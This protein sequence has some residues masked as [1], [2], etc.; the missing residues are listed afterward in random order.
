MCFCSPFFFNIFKQITELNDLNEA[1]TFL[2]NTCTDYI[3]WYEDNR[4]HHDI[5]SVVRTTLLKPFTQWFQS[6]VSTFR[7]WNQLTNNVIDKQCAIMFDFGLKNDEILS[8][9]I[10]DDCEKLIDG[11]V[12]ILSPLSNST[13]GNIEYQFDSHFLVQHNQIKEE[14]IKEGILPQF[15]RCATEIKF[16]PLKEQQPVL[17]ILLAMTF[18][19]QAATLLKQNSQFVSHLKTFLTLSLEQGVRRAA[20]GL[21]WKLEKED[22]AAANSVTNSTMQS[23]MSYKYDIM[24]SYSHSDKDLC[25]RLHDHLNKDQFRVCLNRDDMHGATMVAMADAIENS[26]F[27][28]TCMSDAYKQSAYCQSEAHYAYERRCHLIPIAMKPN[29]R[30]DGWLGFTVSEKIYIDFPKL[31]F[32]QTYLKLKNEIDQ[33]RKNFQHLTRN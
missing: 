13:T 4:R 14:L 23:A 11:S 25:Y 30:P 21:I 17:E 8:G 6:H 18:N 33:Q 24:L 5:Y 20:E 2:V 15:I 16:D 31:G 19:S 3:A 12:F 32:D 27:V 26:Q 29:Y 9:D 1:Q 28:L 22:T 7:Q 10:R